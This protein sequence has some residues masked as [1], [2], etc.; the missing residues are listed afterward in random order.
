MRIC[1]GTCCSLLL[2]LGA[3][4]EDSFDLVP[5]A[6]LESLTVEVMVPP[7]DWGELPVHAVLGSGESA[8]RQPLDEQGRTVFEK[9]GVPPLVVTIATGPNALWT[10][11]G[12]RTGT[13]RF[14]ESG[15][16]YFRAGY[17]VRGRIL[18][19]GPRDTIHLA[20]LEDGERLISGDL[21]IDPDGRGFS[22]RVWSKPRAPEGVHVAAT[23]TRD[24]VPIAH[25]LAEIGDFFSSDRG[26]V[27]IA[28][29]YLVDGRADVTLDGVAAGLTGATLAAGFGHGR[30]VEYSTHFPERYDYRGLPS[31]PVA[32]G[33]AAARF[34]TDPSLDGTPPRRRQRGEWPLEAAG[35]VETLALLPLPTLELPVGPLASPVGLEDELETIA[36]D[37]SS[38]AA[39]TLVVAEAF[40]SNDRGRRAC[41]PFR[42]RFDLDAEAHAIAL[43]KFPAEIDL[44][45]PPRGVPL[46]VE[47]EATDSSPD[48]DR[49]SSTSGA[50]VL[51]DEP[52]C[53][54]RLRPPHWA[55]GSFEHNATER[56]GSGAMRFTL[57][58]CGEWRWIVPDTDLSR[59]GCGRLVEAGDDLVRFEDAT[60][61]V[62]DLVL[63][64]GAIAEDPA[65]QER[66]PEFM[67]I[68]G[69]AP[70]AIPAEIAG[71]WMVSNVRTTLVSL[72]PD[73]PATPA[74]SLLE[75]STPQ[76]LGIFEID[77]LGQLYA[78]R[79]DDWDRRGI[80]ETW[81]GSSGRIRFTNGAGMCSS[82]DRTAGLS[83]VGPDRL[84]LS[85]VEYFVD[86]L[87][88]DGDG[89][90][91]DFVGVERRLELARMTR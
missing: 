14:V 2:L 41:A 22:S 53:G 15:R 64:P 70:A 58:A 59:T 37:L 85:T 91:V 71:R 38:A 7:N 40:Q 43:P 82:V 81:D 45:V 79:L 13:V 20:V 19:A 88:R 77:H 4:A 10:K 32:P 9:P 90:R 63:W 87:D 49:M 68:R 3:C 66:G 89:D 44:P 39:G 18:G 60:G 78:D 67:R 62:R 74:G 17:A 25:G 11:A 65:V 47:L 76:D 61:A 51:G 56:C 26:E 36:Y 55:V 84:E 42:W 6:A 8:R 57:S 73:T 80:V 69:P 54:D 83:S 50:I 75:L 48:G 24:G 16:E 27:E 23:A 31:F 12:I 30:I 52:D 46:T 34:E 28:L 21:A 29:E 86:V 5:P 1:P 33:A 72:P 35:E